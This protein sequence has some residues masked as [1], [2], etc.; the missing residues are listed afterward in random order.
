LT[1]ND[2]D[3]A[4]EHL[5]KAWQNRNELDGSVRLAIK[6]QLEKLA[7]DSDVLRATL[8]SQETDIQLDQVKEEQRRAFSELQ[9]KIMKER[10]QVDGLLKTKPREALERMQSLRNQ[11]AQ[12]NLDSEN[13]RPL[14]TI[15]DRDIAEMQKYIDQNLPEIMNDEANADALER[16]Q[17]ERQHRLDV[18][19]QLQQ[20]VEKYNQLI[21]E[22]RYDEAGRIVSQAADLAPNSEL[23]SLLREKHRV[24]RNVEMAQAIRAAKQDGFILALERAEEASIAWDDRTPMAL[25]PDLEGYTQRVRNRA[26]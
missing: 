23:V 1:T 7:P 15:I 21:K 9:S 18:E 11:V 20:L 13:Q 8:A 4:I 6:T 26:E 17:R 5:Q 25:D 12:S 22:Q 2:R 19:M 24:Q 10:T 14:L 16:V 3:L